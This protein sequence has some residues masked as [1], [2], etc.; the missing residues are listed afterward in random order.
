MLEFGGVGAHKLGL[1]KHPDAKTAVSTGNMR[2]S[3]SFQKVSTI[4]NIFAP[5]SPSCRFSLLLI[6]VGTVG[7][8][9]VLV[10]IL[11]AVSRGSTV[12]VEHLDSLRSFGHRPRR[13][14]HPNY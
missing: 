6:A 5:P 7:G 4:V 11:E 14:T 1:T 9:G 12:T 2:A 10:F 3:I 8:G 13:P